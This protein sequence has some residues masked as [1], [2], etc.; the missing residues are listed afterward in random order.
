MMVQELEKEFDRIRFFQNS[1]QDQD[2]KVRLLRYLGELA[3]FQ[4]A[5]PLLL[6]NQL[7]KY[8]FS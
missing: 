2:R 7:K 5:D 3:K 1:A 6:I 4:V 8:S